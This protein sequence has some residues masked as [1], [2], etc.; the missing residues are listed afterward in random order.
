MC[1]VCSVPFSEI[2]MRLNEYAKEDSIFLCLTNCRISGGMYGDCRI[3]QRHGVR[4]SERIKSVHE[5]I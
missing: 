1:I 5:T 4:A 3:V 2:A